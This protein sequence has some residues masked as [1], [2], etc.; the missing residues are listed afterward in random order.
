MKTELIK[1]HNNRFFTH[2]EKFFDENTLKTIEFF[3]WNRRYEE[4]K[5]LLEH[6]YY[7]NDYYLFIN[8]WKNLIK[9]G[10]V[11]LDIGAGNGN[12]TIPMSIL[13]KNGKVLCF[14]PSQ[15][16]NQVLIPN[17]QINKCTNVL[18]F[19]IAL[20]EQDGFFEFQYEVG[21]TNGGPSK[22]T[23][24]FSIK[25]DGSGYAEKHYLP[26]LNFNNH[27]SEY[28]SDNVISFIK[29][30][31]EGYDLEVLNTILN[32]IKRDKPFIQIEWFGPRHQN[33]LTWALENKYKAYDIDN[34]ELEV[35]IN[36]KK[37]DLLLKPII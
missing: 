17:L 7:I 26:G 18:P 24:L 36:Y 21:M 6:Q 29:I 32:L 35:D 8:R 3:H 2:L 23:S 37:L 27:Y 28:V 12:T 25:T 11:C 16:F 4:D 15:A 5:E 9:N 14:E 22:Y 10:S 33:I 19:N 34:Q 1:I 31:C 30:D 13:N 20:M